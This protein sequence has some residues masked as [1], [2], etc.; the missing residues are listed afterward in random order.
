MLGDMEFLLS[1]VTQYLTSEHREQ[2]GYRVEH[3][4]RNSISLHTHVLSSMFYI[5]FA[6]LTLECNVICG[7]SFFGPEAKNLKRHR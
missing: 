6:P 2:V 3:F 4:G 5:L 7:H 1:C